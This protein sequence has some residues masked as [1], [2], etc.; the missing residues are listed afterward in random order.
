MSHRILIVDD[1]NSVRFA[2]ADYLR[3]LGHSVDCAVEREEAEALLVSRRYS[4]VVADL[5]LTAVHGVEG[6]ELI[7]LAREVCPGTRSVLLTAYASREIEREAS[8]RGAAA[9]L[10][11]PKP[12]AEV[13]QVL[14]ALLEETA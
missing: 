10:Q 2:L 8:R 7:D 6:L 5:R 4:L 12:L 14:T 13:A 11:K 9:V 3:G 1:S